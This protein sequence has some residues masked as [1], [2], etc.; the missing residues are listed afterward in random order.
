MQNWIT[1]LFG[2]TLL[3]GSFPLIAVETCPGIDRKDISALCAEGIVKKAREAMG[4]ATTCVD[5]CDSSKGKEKCVKLCNDL[6]TCTGWDS[7]K[8]SIL[9]LRGKEK[10]YEGTFQA[11]NPAY[12]D[13]S[14]LG[15]CTYELSGQKI[16]FTYVLPRAPTPPPKPKKYVGGVDPTQGP[17]IRKVEVKK[18][19]ATK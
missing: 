10:P 4:K 17:E 9:S 3:A 5:K 16:A 11:R 1:A 12:A 6:H 7:I 18:A 15:M 19:P 14:D 2:A 13:Q 8:K